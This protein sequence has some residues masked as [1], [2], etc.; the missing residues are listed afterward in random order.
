MYYLL[1]PVIINIIYLL[2]KVKKF[3]LCLN[4]CQCVHGYVGLLGWCR[5][6]KQFLVDVDI[7]IS[8]HFIRHQ[9]TDL[10]CHLHVSSCHLPALSIWLSLVSYKY[11]QV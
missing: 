7:W 4:S 1:I 11:N 6:V 9:H 3:I 8:V 2:R 10:T 5:E